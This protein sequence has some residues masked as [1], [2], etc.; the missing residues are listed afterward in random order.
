MSEL[1]EDMWTNE[2]LVREDL[3]VA[4]THALPICSSRNTSRIREAIRKELVRQ[5]ELGRLIIPDAQLSTTKNPRRLAHLIDG[6][7]VGAEDV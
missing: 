1:P 5:V 7:K 6:F 2:H 4:A 3:V